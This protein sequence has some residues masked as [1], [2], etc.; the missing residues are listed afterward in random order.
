[1][2]ARS[3][4]QRQRNLSIKREKQKVKELARLR[5]TVG[6]PEMMDTDQV[7]V[8]TAEQIEKKHK[9]IEEQL[10]EEEF[11]QEKTRAIDR[12]KIKVVH[13]STK[14]THIYDTKTMKDQYGAYPTWYRANKVKRKMN[15]KKLSHKSNFWTANFVPS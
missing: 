12:K 3:K 2:T 13:P 6:L 15:K 11:I 5:K 4:K 1:M 8:Q 10:I 14:K 9:K 7:Q